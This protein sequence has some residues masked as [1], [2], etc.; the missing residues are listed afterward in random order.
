MCIRDRHCAPQAQSK[1]AAGSCP[2]GKPLSR[3]PIPPLLHDRPSREKDKYFSVEFAGELSRKAWLTSASEPGVLA[4]YARLPHTQGCSDV[5][6]R[7]STWIIW[8]SKP[9][10]YILGQAAS[11]P[12]TSMLPTN[13]QQPESQKALVASL[14]SEKCKLYL[15]SSATVV[16]VGH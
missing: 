6:K 2:R 10:M 11:P 9:C 15:A 5:Y 13:E 12:S 16:S 7:Q 3:S 4:E 1:S 8:A 14:E